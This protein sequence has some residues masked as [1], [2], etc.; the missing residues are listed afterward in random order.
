MRFDSKTSLLKGTKYMQETRYY[1]SVTLRCVEGQ[2][3]KDGSCVLS[4][5]R[6]VEYQFC[7]TGLDLKKGSGGSNKGDSGY[8]DLDCDDSDNKGGLATLASKVNK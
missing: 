3:S 1:V 2:A 5:G 7:S 4:N 8:L 6:C